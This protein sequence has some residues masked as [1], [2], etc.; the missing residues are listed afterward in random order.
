MRTG[1]RDTNNCGSI[2][3]SVP[4]LTTIEVEIT[5][6]FDDITKSIKRRLVVKQGLKPSRLLSKETTIPLVLVC[7]GGGQTVEWETFRPVGTHENFRSQE[8]GYG[9]VC[10]S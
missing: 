5:K 1:S 3:T 10:F 9:S 6:R 2:V 4:V 7:G 8:A